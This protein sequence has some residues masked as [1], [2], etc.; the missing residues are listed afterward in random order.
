MALAF[1]PQAEN[2]RY[3]DDWRRVRRVGA[4]QLAHGDADD[5]GYAQGGE[6]PT[7]RGCG[8]TNPGYQWDNGRSG[9]DKFF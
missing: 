1:R 7:N 2:P 6:L 8:W 5:T 4:T 3:V 9:V